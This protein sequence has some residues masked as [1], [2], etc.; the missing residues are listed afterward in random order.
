MLG[1]VLGLLILLWFLG[2][3]NIPNVN[4]PSISL[5]NINNHQI[6]AYEF[7]IFLLIIWSLGLLPSP[8]RQIFAVILFLWILSVLGFIQIAGLSSLLT[9]GIIV[10]LV[11]Y[12]FKSI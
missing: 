2:Y 7:A 4:I 9:I 6:T 8:F 3:V 10:G 12:I 11:V 1:I 5:F